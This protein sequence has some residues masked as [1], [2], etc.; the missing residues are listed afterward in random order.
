MKIMAWL[1]VIATIGVIVSCSITISNEW[2]FRRGCK[3]TVNE[4]LAS[5]CDELEKEVSALRW[6]NSIYK[7]KLNQYVVVT[8]ECGECRYEWTRHSKGL[9]LKDFLNDRYVEY[10]CK[11]NEIGIMFM[12][13]ANGVLMHSKE[14]LERSNTVSGDSFAI[15]A[16][17]KEKYNG[18]DTYHAECGVVT[19]YEFTAGGVRDGD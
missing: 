18:I 19:N 7:N 14:Q 4:E 17:Y 10:L 3:G 1:W 5:K 2:E 13:D 11:T 12:G 16:I 9:D 8:N 6:T 15:V